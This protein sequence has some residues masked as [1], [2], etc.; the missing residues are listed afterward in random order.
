[1]AY[2]AGFIIFPL[3]VLFSSLSNIFISSLSD[4]TL[5]GAVSLSPLAHTL[6]KVLPFVVLITLFTTFYLVVPNAK[7]RFIPA[8]I[9][10]V[11]VGVAFQYFQMLYISGQI[12][13]SRYNSIYGSIAAVPL[14][15]LYINFSWM[16]ALLGTQLCYAIQNVKR[17]AFKKESE[18][19]SR[20]YRDFVALVLMKKVCR[21]F[22]K[23]RPPYNAE[24]LALRTDLPIA[25]V[26]DTLDMLVASRLLTELPVKRNKWAPKYLPAV[27]TS[28]ITVGRV[29]AAL[30]RL[31]SESF[32]VDI[33]DA[34]AEEW[35]L[36]R[37]SR[38]TREM[39]MDTL[40]ANIG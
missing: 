28:T 31:G 34:Y 20:R 3:A 22:I 16:L 33:Y 4:I 11:V 12:W 37:R 32:R 29:M 17:Y 21:G 9:S 19:V 10:G 39:E 5:L 1:M 25:V 15:M 38:R 7:V 35:D 18:T 40:V 13:V 8:L 26:S 27:D 36:V 6:F 24:E 30:D 23:E 2:L 14:L